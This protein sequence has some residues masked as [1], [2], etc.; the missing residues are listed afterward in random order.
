MQTIRGFEGL[1]L[2]PKFDVNA[3]RVG[4]GSD[5][6]TLADGSVKKVTEGMKITPEDA[7]RD[8]SRR[9]DEFMQTV[10]GQIGDAA[11]A[12]LSPSQAAA[13]T[14][15]AYNYGKLPERVVSAV[16]GGGNVAAVIQGLGADNDGVNARR[17]LAEANMW[18]GS[19][20]PMPGTPDLSAPR[21]PV[22]GATTPLKGL[23][24]NAFD[25]FAQLGVTRPPPRNPV[26]NVVAILGAMAGGASGAKNV[27]DLLTAVG[28][29]GG[30]QA[31]KNAN[32]S[33]EEGK[34]F[35]QREDA[36]KRFQAEIGV[37][38][39]EAETQAENYRIEAQN[40]DK[41][42]LNTVATEQAKLDTAAKNR[43]NELKNE[44]D[45]KKW[46]RFEPQVKIDKDGV[47]VVKRKPDGSI[48]IT[49]TRGKDMD[50]QAEA[51]RNA[52]TIYGKD[53]A[54]VNAL[55]YQALGQAGEPYV[56]RQVMKDMVDD[57]AVVDILGPEQYKVLEKEAEKGLDPA[58]RGK[59]EYDAQ[60]KQRMV[61]LLWQQLKGKDAED[62]A[63][64]D[65]LWLLPMLR[66]GNPG[67]AML[68]QPGG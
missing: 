56:R 58:L 37:R 38:K 54:A 17:R 47:T 63:K 14:S 13:L 59:E 25:Q 22:P 31:A 20:N 32:L 36:M 49:S 4:Y 45:W 12:S 60:K 43:M 10:K 6:V 51:I 30:Q 29:A 52:A 8:L 64:K 5:T 44:L 61:D 42:L 57:N 46:E 65:N 18:D 40:R 34:E 16:K 26:D 7:E 24:A 2:E 41:T 3:Q 21:L 39:A 68:A 35:S 19:G 33:R 50:A 23:P 1:I 11:F 28:G 27:G 55:R 66:R 62:Q 53:S 9:T 48:D 15:V 67:A